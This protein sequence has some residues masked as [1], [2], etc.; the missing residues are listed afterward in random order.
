MIYRC[1]NSDCHSSTKNKLVSKDGFYFR[2]S[3]SRKIQRFVCKACGQKF[4]RAT[5][6]LEKYQKKRRINKMLFHDL[7][8]NATMRESARKYNVNY[9]TIQS[10]MNYF[11]LRARKK[12]KE[13]L[14]KLKKSKVTAMQF[15]DLITIEHTKMK[16]LSITIAV[17]KD[18]RFVLAAEVS[19]IPAFG[20]LADKSRKKYG[21]RKSNHEKALKNVFEKIKDVVDKDALIESDE[22]KTYPKF[23]SRYFHT[24]KYKRYK[25]GRGCIAGQGELKKLHFDPLFTLNHT[26]AMFRARI[27]RLVRKTWCTTKRIDMLQK[28]VDIFI[29][30]Y[31]LVYLKGLVPI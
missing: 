24:A 21:Y 18:R 11:S 15:D 3:D 17:D 1:P 22:H 28:H 29:H 19:T 13:F 16:P 30:H 10:R 9:K 6:T 8:T 12:Q 5:F 20:L 4:S 23:V 26:C 31:N 27:N 14:G 7:A 25:G 2:R